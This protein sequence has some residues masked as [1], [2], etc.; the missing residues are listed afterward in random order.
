MSAVDFASWVF[1]D[2]TL[3]LRGRDYTVPPPSVEASKQIVA[4]AALLEIKF[5]LIKIPVPPEMQS[6]LE[7]IGDRHPALGDEAYAEMVADGLPAV[8]INR[9]SVYATLYW[10][11]G[12]EYA[13]TMARVLWTPEVVAEAAERA[14]GEGDP[15]V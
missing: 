10:A 13:E 8:V 3:T 2:L 12:R 6:V 15:K 14:G 7:S 5:G 9:M 1:P 4:A 11:R